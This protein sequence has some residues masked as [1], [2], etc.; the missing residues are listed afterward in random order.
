MCEAVGHPVVSLRGQPSGRCEIGKLAA[1]EWR[2]LERGATSSASARRCSDRIARMRLFALRGANSVER[3]EPSRILEATTELMREI[4]RRNGLEPAQTVSCIFTATA[5]LSSEFPAVAARAIGFDRVPAAVRA[6]DSRPRLDAPGDQGPDPLL[7][8]GRSRARPRLSRRD[9]GAASRPPRGTIGRWRSSSQSASGAS[10]STPPRAAT[11]TTRSSALLA[12]N[13][14]PFEPLPAVREAIERALGTPQPLPRPL[15]LAA[16]GEAQRALRSA[17]VA[18]RHRK[19]LLRHPAGRRRGAARAGSRAD[20]RLAL[21]LDLP[22]PRRR[23]G[24][25]GGDRPARRA[26]VPRPRGRCCARSP[27]RPAW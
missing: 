19:R 22:A 10:P 14:S 8:R 11:A 21:V 9:Q 17:A 18:D 27:S 7:R 6:G 3:D 12:S 15:Q 26:R 1:G 2:L 23:L 24:C 16:A 20:L 4:T 13:E 5:D 25:P